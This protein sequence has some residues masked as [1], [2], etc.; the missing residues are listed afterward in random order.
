MYTGIGRNTG[1]P[2]P[3]PPSN[4]VVAPPPP[5]A[6]VSPSI[7]ATENDTGAYIIAVSSPIKCCSRSRSPNIP[8]IIERSSSA[9]RPSQL[10]HGLVAP[11]ERGAIAATPNS[12]SLLLGPMPRIRSML[13]LSFSLVPS[14]GVGAVD[15]RRLCSGR[16]GET[17]DD[18]DRLQSICSIS[19]VSLLAIAVGLAA[20]MRSMSG[21]FEWCG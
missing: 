13:K 11:I 20:V 12:S 4:G 5:F 19:S 17:A 16:F 9:A 15:W 10:G 21:A 1:F 7:D 6:D 14:G 18:D 8:P 3:I 2:P